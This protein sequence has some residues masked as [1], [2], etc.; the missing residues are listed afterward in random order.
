MHV[1]SSYRLP[2][3]LTKAAACLSYIPRWHF[4]VKQQYCILLYLTL[5]VYPINNNIP[6]SIQSIF[7]AQ[8]SLTG[9]D[10]PLFI[11]SIITAQTQTYVCLHRDITDFLTTT[12]M[13]SCSSDSLYDDK[14]MT[15]P[16]R[17]QQYYITIQH[18]SISRSC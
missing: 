14:H 9:D 4:G 7:T 6:V 17:G 12:F 16:H 3:Q 2:A 1:E 5:T 15:L 10:I 18:N 11:A 8:T 13:C